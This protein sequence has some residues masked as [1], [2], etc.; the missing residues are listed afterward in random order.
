M[1]VYIYIYICVYIYIYIYIYTGLTRPWAT[2][3]WSSSTHLPAWSSRNKKLPPWLNVYCYNKTE[4]EESVNYSLNNS[5]NK[6]FYS[7]GAT[8]SKDEHTNIFSQLFNVICNHNHNDIYYTKQHIDV[9]Y[10]NKLCG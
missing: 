4:I 2:S 10:Y 1:C 5:F 3:P 8:Y 7:K 6:L 9:N